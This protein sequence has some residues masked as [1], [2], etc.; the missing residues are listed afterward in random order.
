M[1]GA[2]HW[3]KC[4]H[5]ARPTCQAAEPPATPRAA[6]RSRGRAH[7]SGTALSRLTLHPPARPP[8]RRAQG[9]APPGRHSMAGS[10]RGWPPRPRGRAPP[11]ALHAAGRHTARHRCGRTAGLQGRP[12]CLLQAALGP[13]AVPAA[14]PPP[15][16]QP[17]GPGRQGR[18]YRAAGARL[19]RP[20]LPASLRWQTGRAGHSV[21]MPA[22]PPPAPA[23][24]ATAAGRHPA[25]AAAPLGWRPCCRHAVPARSPPAAAAVHWLGWAVRLLLG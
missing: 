5:A 22:A 17:T 2:S 6:R 3:G 16:P 25:A 10:L 8:G 4:K 20:V 7:A 11:P 9:R 15:M 1:W 23:A 19:L 24:A 21:D 12:R 13:R 14:A 18:A